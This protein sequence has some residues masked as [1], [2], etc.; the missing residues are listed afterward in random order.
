MEGLLRSSRS[1]V[2]WRTCRGVSKSP[3]SSSPHG[4]RHISQPPRLLRS[5]STPSGAAPSCSPC[6]RAAAGLRRPP[7][8]PVGAHPPHLA[9]RL[10]PATP[11]RSAYL[12]GPSLYP[13]GPAAELLHAPIALPVM[14]RLPPSLPRCQGPETV[15]RG[16]E[17][18]VRKAPKASGQPRSPPK[19]IEIASQRTLDG[20]VLDLL[21]TQLPKHLIQVAQAAAREAAPHEKHPKRIALDHMCR[22]PILSQTSGGRHGMIDAS[23]KLSP[24][25]EA[26]SKASPLSQGLFHASLTLLCTAFSHARGAEASTSRLLRLG[27]ATKRR[28]TP[29][30]L[31]LRVGPLSS[32]LALGPQH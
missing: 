23:S 4:A 21:V 30:S 5:P 31:S 12:R 24:R 18:P 6:P 8:Q 29:R 3:T 19:L 26:R 9:V 10:P 27:N 7:W 14:R 13:E 11:Q 25:S 32:T 16:A 20:S 15:R 1:P 2:L 28:E 17:H 22:G